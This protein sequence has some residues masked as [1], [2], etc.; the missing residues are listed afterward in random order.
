MTHAL[1][2][3]L[4]AFRKSQSVPSAKRSRLCDGAG[5]EFVHVLV[6][7]ASRLAYIEVLPD[8]ERQPPT[9]VS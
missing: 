5:W 9:N 2:S 3:R 7:D 1:S 8:E 4:S 6:D